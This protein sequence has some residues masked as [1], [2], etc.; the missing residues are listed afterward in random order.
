VARVTPRTDTGL[1]AD[2]LLT[3][4]TVTTTVAAADGFDD[5]AALLTAPG[6]RR[7]VVTGNGAQWHAALALSLAWMHV[8]EPPVELIAVPGGL[9]ARGAVPWRD[10]DR[11]LALSSSGEFRDVIEA[12]AAGAPRP[13]AA[14]T[15]NAGS[16]IGKAADA[17]AMVMVETLRA[18]THTQGYAGSLAAGLAVI[19]RMSGDAALAAAV[20]GAGARLAPLVERAAALPADSGPRPHAGVCVGTDPAWPAALHTALC[21]REVSILPVDGYETREGATTGRFATV[22]GDLAVSIAGMRPDPLLDE[23]E[24]I[25]EEG[26]ARV[27]R[28]AGDADADPRLAPIMALPQA[29]ALA[30]DLAQM[31]GLDADAPQWAGAYDKTSRGPGR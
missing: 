6:V 26:G 25:L 3:P 30:I 4:G 10:G 29:I 12:I 13:I 15:A 21:L 27:V 18:R 11:L 17:R 8:P 31:A 5:V 7:V 20:S 16:T 9:V 19:A 28:I 14:I 2:L 1:F 23:A 24:G 22:P